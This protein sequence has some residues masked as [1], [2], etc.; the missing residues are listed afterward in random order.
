MP[1]PTPTKHTTG[2]HRT[3]SELLSEIHR[4]RS[5]DM[6]WTE[7]GK[8]VGVSPRTAKRCHEE[9]DAAIKAA[10]ALAYKV[11]RAAEREVSINAP[12]PFGIATKIY[13]ALLIALVA[14]AAVLLFRHG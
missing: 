6:N 10:R 11:A 9:V 1:N 5:I 7:I 14:V 3:R 13:V 12:S 8:L 4:L 2:K